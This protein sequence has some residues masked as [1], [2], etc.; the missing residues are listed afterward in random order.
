M[1]PKYKFLCVVFSVLIIFSGCSNQA[2]SDSEEPKE[3]SEIEQ[4]LLEKTKLTDE[5][6][7]KL[8]LAYSEIKDFGDYYSFLCESD[9]KT[10][11]GMAIISHGEV[12]KIDVAE[13]DADAVF[14]VHTF[15][16]A[17]GNDD[18]SKSLFFACSGVINEDDIAKIHVF[19]SGNLMYEIQIGDR[20]T[21]DIVIADNQPTILKI[22]ALD[23]D[24]NIIYSFPPY[25]PD[26]AT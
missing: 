17:T 26:K 6:I 8:S 13:H 10:Y 25:P 2:T 11:E 1:I 12:I 14:T 20:C 22:D 19:L 18:G 16:G 3:T 5:K 24:D 15:S 4:L 9:E 21:Y 23:E 7:T